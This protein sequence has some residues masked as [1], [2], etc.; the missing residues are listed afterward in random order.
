MTTISLKL[1]EPLLKDLE[2]EA[3]RRGLTK[4]ALI[5]RSLEGML[6][7]KSSKTKPS[8]LELMGNL[9]GSFKGPRDLSVN[10]NHLVKAITDRADRSGKNNR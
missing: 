7:H 9:V 1:P 5:R 10:R 3:E 8:C 4:S 6:R 2:Q